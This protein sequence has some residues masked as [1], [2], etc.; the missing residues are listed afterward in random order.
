MGTAAAVER[1]TAAYRAETDVIDRFFADAC[2]FG[3][4]ERVS[5]KELFEAWEEWCAEEGVEPRGQTKF[6]RVM[7]E[8]GVVKKFAEAK[9]GGT[10]LWKG[11]GLAGNDGETAPNRES[12]P[13]ENP[14][15]HGGGES[16]VGHFDENSENF[17]TEP[18]TRE[19]FSENGLKVPQVP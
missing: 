9:I 4:E 13:P 11:I 17:S 19:G 6:T 1:A 16:V 2:V 10:R 3:P 7:G 18:P 14:C 5:K 15:K 8:R 12:A